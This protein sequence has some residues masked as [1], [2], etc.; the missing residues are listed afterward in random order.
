[1]PHLCAYGWGQLL[2]GLCFACCLFF[3]GDVPSKEGPSDHD[4]WTFGH[5]RDSNWRPHGSPGNSN[6]VPLFQDERDLMFLGECM[7]QNVPR[8]AERDNLLQTSCIREESNWLS[9]LLQHLTNYVE[10][11]VGVE[12][13][14]SSQNEGFLLKPVFLQRWVALFPLFSTLCHSAVS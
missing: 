11:Y 6:L 7:E 9:C 5:R 1:M 12:G 4:H 13:T 10:Q 2:L 8:R 14:P 3:T